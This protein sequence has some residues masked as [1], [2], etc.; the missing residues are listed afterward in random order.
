MYVYHFLFVIF[1]CFSSY[2]ICVSFTFFSFFMVYIAYNSLVSNPAATKQPGNITIF[3]SSQ[4]TVSFLRLY[5]DAKHSF[6]YPY[7]TAIID[8]TKGNITRITWDDAC[9]FCPTNRCEE[10]TFDFAGKMTSENKTKGIGPTKGCYYTRNSTHDECK[11]LFKNNRTD[12]DLSIYVAWTGTD[13]MDKP[14]FS[15]T[16]RYSAFSSKSVSE[17]FTDSFYKM[18]GSNFFTNFLG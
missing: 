6:T 14:L 7:L 3:I 15:S 4:T 5:H 8:V 2:N 12:C 9:I 13:S 10:N 18:F 1:F 11:E 17:Q 16:K